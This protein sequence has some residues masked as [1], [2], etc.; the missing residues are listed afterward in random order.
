MNTEIMSGYS[1]LCVSCFLPSSEP[2]AETS[3]QSSDFKWI[4]ARHLHFSLENSEC[5]L[6]ENAPCYLQKQF[7]LSYM[8]VGIAGFA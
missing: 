3:K 8:T 4:C 7:V 5:C 6:V 2:A 1:A